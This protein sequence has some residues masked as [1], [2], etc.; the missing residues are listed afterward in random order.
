MFTRKN[1]MHVIIV[2]IRRNT[3]MFGRAVR[4]VGDIGAL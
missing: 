1:I 4:V 2:T 3:Y